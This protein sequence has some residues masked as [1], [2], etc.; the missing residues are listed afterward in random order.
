MSVQET[1]AGWLSGITKE[2]VFE[3]GV[4]GG[5]IIVMLLLIVFAF[6][7]H[8]VDFIKNHPSEF[9]GEA[10]VVGLGTTIPVL[11]IGFRR[12]NPVGSVMS[13][14]FIGFLVFFIFH[15]LMEFAG[16]NAKVASSKLVAE[17]KAIFWPVVISV[18]LISLILGVIAF[19]VRK[20][21]MCISES[22]LES[23]VFG[24]FN[25][26][27]FLWIEYNRGER[28][29]GNLI[30]AFLKYFFAFFIGCMVLQAGG[31]WSNVFPLSV[32]KKAEYSTCSDMFGIRFSKNSNK[33]IVEN[34][35]GPKNIK[36]N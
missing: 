16:Q 33:T 10:I 36:L 3:G 7:N 30:V 15:I 13:A 26:S 12:G 2:G 14:G 28:N 34:V 31:F 29:I 5:K 4:V 9:L 22:I 24:L 35:G 19:Q 23:V 11:F 1:S 6:M 20:F 21:D 25:A 32:E 8:D 27:P 17:E 18:L